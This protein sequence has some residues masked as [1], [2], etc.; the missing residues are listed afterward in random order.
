M[1]FTLIAAVAENQV[2]GVNNDLP[3]HLP[4]DM[5]HFMNTTK[6]HHVIM[7]R[8]NYES[9]PDRYR[10]L[11][12][13][14]NIVV[15]RQK[16]Y[17]AQGC[18]VVNT[19]DEALKIPEEHGEKEAFV[20]G[21]AEIF[22]LCIDRADKMILTEIQA[23]V[24]GDTFFPRFDKRDWKEVSRLPHPADEKHLYAF[25]FVTYHRIRPG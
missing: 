7:G 12:E 25:D 3:W 15:T 13:R 4:D 16:K 19:L 23:T 18:M 5:K 14:T 20:I 6:G 11:P 21:G 10:P 2:I 1:I 9:I 17:K 22:R 8:K 24:K